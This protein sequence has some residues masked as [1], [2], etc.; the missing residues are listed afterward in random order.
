MDNPRSVIPEKLQ[1][2]YI[3]WHFSPGH[4]AENILFISG[5]TGAL[6]GKEISHD[7][8]EQCR[9][10]FSKVELTLSE[11]NLDFSDIVELTTYHIGLKEGLDAFK[12]V[13][14]EFIIEPYPAWTAIGVSELAVE[15]AMI[16]I[17]ATASKTR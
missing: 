13:K 14:D 2:N 3:D 16:E 1:S 12:A 8:A 10:A 5:C 6:E 4:W 15:G 17:R 9:S 11:A 7:L